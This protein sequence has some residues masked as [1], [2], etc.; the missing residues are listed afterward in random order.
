MHTKSLRSLACTGALG[1][2]LAA[3]SASAQTNM[4][5]PKY[6]G[7][8]EIST[9]YGSLS[10]LSFDSYDWNWKHN[11]DTGQVYEQLFTADLSKAKSRGGPNGFTSDTYIPSNLI[12]GE[13]AEKWEWLENP[14]RVKITL[15]QR[16]M[17]PEKTG[18]MAKRELVADDV[19]FSFKRLAS[20]PKA[21]SGYFDHI[22]DVRAEGKYTVVFEMSKFNAEWDYRF[23]YGF[24][25]GITPKEVVAAGAGD[26]K[27][28]NGT[29]PFKLTDYVQ[30]NSQTYEKNADY[31]DKE[32]IS[33][34]EFKLPY[35]DK[36]EYRIIKDAATRATALRTG[37]L[38]IVEWMNWQDAEQ[39]KKSTPSLKWNRWLSEG[40]FLSMRVDRKPFDDVRVRRA[41]NMAVNKQEI[42]K[43]FYNGNAELFA[44]PQHPDYTGYFQSL[45]EQ[46]A[47]VRELFEYDPVTAKKLLAE[48][49]YPNGFAFKT[50]VTSASQD[51]L[52]LL[53]LVAAYLEQVGVK[54]EIQPMEYAAFLSAMTTRTVTAGYFMSSGHVSPTTT[55]RKSFMTGQTWN[56]SQWSDPKLDERME[57]AY[58]ERDES[59][60]QAAL[61][62]IT[63]EILD[64]AP[65]IWLP[66]PYVYTAWWPWVKGYAGELRAGAVRPG[67]IYARIWI[68]QD[69]KKKMGY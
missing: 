20:S 33:G 43:S 29:G 14:L 13:L 2:L 51:Q 32:T 55:I 24:Y 52:D 61:R 62:A 30:G 4:E 3:G 41:L 48:A 16:V 35:V 9:V 26:W 56:P 5:T 40:I 8:L 27:N 12:R 66:T 22:K 59:K 49:G 57:A 37:K 15:R 69:L 17:F 47:S 64:K 25:S 45:E 23:G 67:P 34:N 21:Q 7:T 65:Y 54:L 38:D 18:V 39:L 63:T 44:Y 46:P 31:W 28:L 36:V 60:R 11:H 42:I 50:Q 1:L 10:A 19:V 6:G 58:Q 53:S 68:D